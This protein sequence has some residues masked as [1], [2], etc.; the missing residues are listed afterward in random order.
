[1]KKREEK[2]THY[3]NL[4]FLHILQLGQGLA[5]D[6]LQPVMLQGRQDAHSR[7]PLWMN[8]SSCAISGSLIFQSYISHL[9]VAYVDGLKN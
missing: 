3:G 4:G 6:S 5:L 2:A 1:M 7:S 8:V 9:L